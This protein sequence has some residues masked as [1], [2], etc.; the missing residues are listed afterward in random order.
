MGRRADR[1][2]GRHRLEVAGMIRLESFG[3]EW[4]S[5]FTDLGE[6]V[7]WEGAIAAGRIDG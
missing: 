5:T 3:D 7:M 1:V 6:S 2:P 4:R